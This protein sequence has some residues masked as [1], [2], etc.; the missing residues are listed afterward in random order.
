VEWRREGSSMFR[1]REEVLETDIFF[2]LYVKSR[3]W[4][5]WRGEFEG[6]DDNDAQG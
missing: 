6:T 5:G 2:S 1:R 3:V 4:S